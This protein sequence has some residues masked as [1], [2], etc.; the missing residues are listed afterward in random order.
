MNT[1]CNNPG[2]SPF[3]L[4]QLLIFF[5]TLLRKE[6]KN[7]N[8]YIFLS[9]VN[10]NRYMKRTVIQDLGKKL[11]LSL[12]AVSFLAIHE[13]KAQSAINLGLTTGVNYGNLS[14]DVGTWNGSL[15]F[16]GALSLEWRYNNK[17]GIALEGQDI[18][19]TTNSNYSDSL[20]YYNKTLKTSYNT[21]L[22]INFLQSSLLFKYYIALGSKP[23]TP[24]D[25]PN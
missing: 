2:S 17:F 18:N 10:L 14:S 23:I 20:L 8:F 7:T 5:P 4:K 22:T 25:N 9:L 24:Y 1:P 11:L 12:A 16:Q 19:L 13:S 6:T 15:G 21:H 3:W